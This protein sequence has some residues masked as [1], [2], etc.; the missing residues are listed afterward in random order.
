LRSLATD[1]HEPGF[2]RETSVWTLGDL[3]CADA[4]KQVVSALSNVRVTARDTGMP[5]DHAVDFEVSPSSRV[6]IVA[7][8]QLAALRDVKA[9]SELDWSFAREVISAPHP[10][11]SP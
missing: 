10:Q 6:C 4:I 9:L 5:G 11:E 1:E 7:C 2:I 8:K 3:K